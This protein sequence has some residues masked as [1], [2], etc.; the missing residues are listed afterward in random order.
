ML[1]I[2]PG[3]ESRLRVLVSRGLPGRP[4]DILHCQ[5][6]QKQEQLLLESQDCV[7]IMYM[8]NKLNCQAR[9]PSPKVQSQ[10]YNEYHVSMSHGKRY[11]ISAIPSMQNLL[12]KDIRKQKM[13]LKQLKNSPMS[14]TNFPC[15]D[16]LL[17]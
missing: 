8:S 6:I 2:L 9:V 17:R 3:C 15:M 1:S 11:A 10:S 13:F 7:M 16:L 4:P 14:P 5:Q 12:N